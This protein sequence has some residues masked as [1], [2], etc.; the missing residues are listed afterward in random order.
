M[1]APAPARLKIY[2]TASRLVTTLVDEL[3]AVGRHN[4]VWDGRNATG[5]SVASGVY[6]YR[7]EAGT[8]VQTR[9]MTLV[10]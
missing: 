4:V 2:D 9:R 1:A 6:L 3:L 10:K 7:F 8:T 5:Q